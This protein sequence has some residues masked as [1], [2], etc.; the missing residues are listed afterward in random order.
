MLMFRRLKPGSLEGAMQRHLLQR[1]LET[2]SCD[3]AEPLGIG[4]LGVRAFVISEKH[5][6]GY[7]QIVQAAMPCEIE[8]NRSALNSIAPRK[9]HPGV[10][11]AV[12]VDASLKLATQQAIG[13]KFM[14]DLVEMR[15]DF[16]RRQRILLR[17]RPQSAEYDHREHCK[18]A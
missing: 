3:L 1:S 16:R 8:L 18:I 7:L 6:S 14:G 13:R 2:V 15:P 5:N 17:G 12:T 9:I 10:R 4:N 11:P